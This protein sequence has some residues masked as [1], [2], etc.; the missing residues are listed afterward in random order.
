VGSRGGDFGEAEAG[1]R[2]ELTGSGDRTREEFLEEGFEPASDAS[3]SVLKSDNPEGPPGER[4]RGRDLARCGGGDSVAE[5]H[6][7]SWITGAAWSF[8]SIAGGTALVSS[9][10]WCNSGGDGISLGGFEG[11]T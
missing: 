2:G 8:N 7:D 6:V 1:G 9:R 5:E 11:Q 4:D 10:V 3:Y